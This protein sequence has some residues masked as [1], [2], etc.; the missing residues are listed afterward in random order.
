VREGT[1]RRVAAFLWVLL[2]GLLVGVGYGSLIG[3]AGWGAPVLGGMF[4]AVHGVAI[5]SAIGVLEIFAIRT[6]LGRALEQAPLVVTILVKALVYGTLVAAVE[7]GDLGERLLRGAPVS[8]PA[9]AALRPL[10]VVFSFVFTFVFLFV[11]HVSRLVG[12]R[13]LRDVVLG[14]YHRPRIEHRFVLFV[15]VVGST[16][17]AERIGP[18]AVH[19]LLGRVFTLAAEPVADHHGEIYQYVGDEMV[20]TW[21]VHRGRDGARPI[22]CFFALAD[23]LSAASDGFR[24]DFGTTPAVR[25][26]LHAGPVVAGEVGE[27]KREIVFHGDVMNATARLEQTARELGHQLLVSG[28]ARGLLTGLD[29]Y[30]FLSLGRGTLRG[31]A[32]TIEMFAATRGA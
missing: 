29:A 21:P 32:E 19:R 16:G 30:T 18:L 1:R 11:L 10:S 9:Q 5:A 25:G 7:L 4:G 6:S 2:A 23:A 17:T 27:S 12:G 15:D 3:F 28:Q 24:R 22:R 8:D 31:R 20:V 14:R 26:A 13:T